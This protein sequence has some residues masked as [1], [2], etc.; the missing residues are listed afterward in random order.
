[1]TKKVDGNTAKMSMP[2]HCGMLA[3]LLTAFAGTAQAQIAMDFVSRNISATTFAFVYNGASY[4]ANQLDVSY[5]LGDYDQSYTQG[6]S[7]SAIQMQTT[8]SQ[9]TSLTV[10]SANVLFEG[11]LHLT[12]S[13]EQQ[14]DGAGNAG[15]EDVDYSTSA[16]II[17][18]VSETVDFALMAS[19]AHS[20]EF[21]TYAATLTFSGGSM[22][23]VVVGD[24][25]GFPSGPAAVNVNSTLAPGQY[26]LDVKV[27]NLWSK[28]A[29][30]ASK[31]DDRKVEFSFHAWAPPSGPHIGSTAVSGTNFVASG[32]GGV[33]N[34]TY[35]VLS[36]TELALPLA[37]WSVV[38][39]NFFD[40]IGNFE[41][42]QALTPGVPL[43]SYIISLP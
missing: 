38:S 19:A 37:K 40:G 4:K 2:S 35:H 39:T 29:T 17:F 18:S 34:G 28:F 43:R 42:T 23:T 27:A 11:T 12:T 6:A 36:S 31:L 26:R 30:T 32:S 1:M 13:L 41:F 24:Q 21:G 8:L 3:V 7:L 15:V 33:P 9:R 10:S 16:G 5:A 22:K 14:A 20:I 25:S